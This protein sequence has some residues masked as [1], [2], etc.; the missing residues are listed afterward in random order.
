MTTTAADAQQA[1]R[2]AEQYSLDLNPRRAYFTARCTFCSW[3][4]T[5]GRNDGAGFWRMIDVHS[6]LRCD[7]G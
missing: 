6:Y 3:Q 1:T 4:G 2:D 7:L 5:A